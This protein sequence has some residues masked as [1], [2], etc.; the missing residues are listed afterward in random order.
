MKQTIW[1]E[2]IAVDVTSHLEWANYYSWAL[3]LICCFMILEGKLFEHRT[4]V[5]LFFATPLST[6][7]PALKMIWI[8]AV[9]I[10]NKSWSILFLNL[11]IIFLQQVFSV[12]LYKYS[13][14]NK[15]R[16]L[17]SRSM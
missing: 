5:A 7:F 2:Y 17:S 11:K 4:K 3:N 13:V 14:V 9:K 1:S 16:S 15:D 6:M 10:K 12:Y 8:T